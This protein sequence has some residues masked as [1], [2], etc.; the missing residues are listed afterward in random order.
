LQPQQQSRR[1]PVF[2][3]TANPGRPEQGGGLD[4][5][6]QVEGGEAVRG[7]AVLSWQKLGGPLAA[8][9]VTRGNL[10]R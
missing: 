2:N 8:N 9:V 6:C 7:T 1:K 5:S 3:I 4:L 10:L